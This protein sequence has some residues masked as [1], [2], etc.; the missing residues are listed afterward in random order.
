MGIPPNHYWRIRWEVT[1]DDGTLY[2]DY[3]PI[4]YTSYKECKSYADA[5]NASNSSREVSVYHYV[6]E[7]TVT[8]ILDL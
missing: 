4:Q 1:R 7:V 2:R 6:E 8:P 3:T 5:L